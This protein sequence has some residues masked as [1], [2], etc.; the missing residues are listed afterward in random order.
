[1]K[2]SWLEIIGNCLITHL[3]SSRSSRPRN[4]IGV[5]CIADIFFTNW[6]MREALINVS[7]CYRCL[8]RDFVVGV[9][10][11][12]IICF[13]Q[14]WKWSEDQRW[15]WKAGSGH[16]SRF[17]CIRNQAEEKRLTEKHRLNPKTD[18]QMTFFFWWI[19]RRPNLQLS[20]LTI[21]SP[22]LW[23]TVFLFTGESLVLEH[24]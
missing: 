17:H 18:L 19:V 6:A 7:C 16:G 13:M 15:L 14:Y 2:P 24:C 11:V 8:G 10:I 4:Q 5:F 20:S 12:I 1:M 3:F 21:P 22:I 9:I 23:E